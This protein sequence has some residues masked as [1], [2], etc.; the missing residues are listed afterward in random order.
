[1]R[2]DLELKKVTAL[3]A[4]SVCLDIDISV[5]AN[6]LL[7]KGLS[8]SDYFV[9]LLESDLTYDAVRFLARGLPRREAVWWSFLS[10]ERY[11]KKVSGNRVDC[12]LN[13]IEQWVYQPDEDK[14]YQ[15]YYYAEE[16]ENDGPGYWAAMAVFWSGGSMT[17]LNSTPIATPD[18]LCSQAVAGAVMLAG[19][20]KSG[21][22]SNSE[23]AYIIKQGL[24][25]ANGENAR[26]ITL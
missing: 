8:P 25:I 14:R 21:N 24:A 20:D 10:A 4:E 18:Y 16:L 22:G 26:Q 7:H 3:S 9:I 17:P 11:Y 12:A 2:N 19:L 6:A 15:A 23:Y 1:M 13:L 5:Q